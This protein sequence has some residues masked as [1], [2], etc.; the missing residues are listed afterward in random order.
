[1]GNINNIITNKEKERK[2]EKIGK[3]R[4]EGKS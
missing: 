3:E 1:L 2:Q 4:K